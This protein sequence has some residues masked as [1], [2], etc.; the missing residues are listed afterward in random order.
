M[1]T[2]TP[3]TDPD[4]STP[5]GARPDPDD[6]TAIPAALDEL[7]EKLI[8]TNGRV[9][10]N[11]FTRMARKERFPDQAGFDYGD[12]LS[13]VDS[14]L[15]PDAKWDVLDIE[16]HERVQLEG[17]ADRSYPPGRIAGRPG[18]ATCGACGTTR[19]NASPP[20]RSLERAMTDALTLSD[21]LTE[22]GVHHNWVVLLERVKQFKRT[23]RLASRDR[24][25]FAA[26]TTLAIADSADLD[27]DSLLESNDDRDRY[28]RYDDGPR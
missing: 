10:S 7:Y 15:P 9:C 11:C 14:N 22:F 24:D 18:M 28:D 8:H 6:L 19:V 23:P 5:I 25:I 2:H 27:I 26:A 17:R 16:Y 1:S 12:L 20:P 3:T 13:F 4:V 21:T